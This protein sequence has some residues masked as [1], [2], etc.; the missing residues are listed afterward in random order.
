M[1]GWCSSITST[2]SKCRAA[3][4]ANRIASTAPSAKFGATRTPTSGRR[5]QVGPHR[6]EPVLGPA[7]G[8]DDGVQPVR[9]AERDVAGGGV[10][11]R[12]VHDH[13]GT[14]VHHGLRVVVLVDA[15]D[16]LEVVGGLDR[17]AGGGAHPSGGAHHGDPGALHASSVHDHEPTGGS[18]LEPD[19][20]RE[21]QLA[22][23]VDRRG[24]PAHVR[25]PRVASRDS[26]PP[27]VSFSPPK[28]PP[29]SAPEVPMLT[30]AMPQ[31]EPAAARNALGLAPGRWVKMLDDRPCGTALCSSIAS[32]RVVV[33][34]ARRGS[35]RRSR[36]RTTS[37]CA[38]IRTTAGST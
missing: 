5:G 36:V 3:T 21:R 11:H 28:A 2:D 33:R 32:S 17:G 29:I 30:L 26:R 18:D 19:A 14:G 27:P 6:R 15:G 4:V 34:S 31:S 24:G 9:H 13:R 10:R 8:A 20:L 25:L 16:Q 37:V 38:G 12:E 1:S 22:G 35:V 23:V 7:G